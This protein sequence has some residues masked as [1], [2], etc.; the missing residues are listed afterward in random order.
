MRAYQEKSCDILSGKQ[1][2]ESAGFLPAVPVQTAVHFAD[3]SRRVVCTFKHWGREKY[4]MN[5][6]NKR[7]VFFVILCIILALCLL[8]ATAF[9]A[10]AAKARENGGAGQT[11]ADTLGAEDKTQAESL[12]Q[13]A[14]FQSPVYD[15]ISLPEND[16]LLYL[17]VVL[18][19][20]SSI[21]VAGF[22][23]YHLRK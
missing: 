15:E 3:R 21:G 11:R 1:Q 16:G 10:N 13:A 5:D 18:F 12:E 2:E 19:A 4:A 14:S 6:K 17:W 20:A 9:A 23:A 22:V 8:L 7:K